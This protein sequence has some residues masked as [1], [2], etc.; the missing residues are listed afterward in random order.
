MAF[1]EEKNGA[2][3]RSFAPDAYDCIVVMVRPTTEYKAVEGVPLHP[4]ASSPPIVSCP[5]QSV[6]RLS[7]PDSW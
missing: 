2:T 3:P 6:H 1:A 4:K 5:R 7:L